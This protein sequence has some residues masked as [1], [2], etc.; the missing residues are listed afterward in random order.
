MLFLRKNILLFLCIFV[1]LFFILF[2][3]LYFANVSKIGTDAVSW[4]LPAKSILNGNGVPYQDYWDTKPNGLILFSTVWLSTFGESLGSF[5]FLHILLISTCVF[6]MLRVFYL[7]FPKTLYA[8][9]YSLSIIVFLSPRIQTQ[10]LLIEL[11]GL[12]F[13][14]IALMF[15]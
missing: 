14:V 2:N 6:G 15:Y 12:S 7:A 10:P 8:L 9:F 3:L 5:R 13:S 11:F 4:F 1:G